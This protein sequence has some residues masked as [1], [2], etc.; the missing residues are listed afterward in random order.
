MDEI[1]QDAIEAV[2]GANLA[3]SHDGVTSMDDSMI[4]HLRS[5]HGLEAEPQLSPST[6]EGLHDRLHLQA[7]ASDE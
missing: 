7:K 5:V 6:Q 1:P 4:E 2:E 3:H